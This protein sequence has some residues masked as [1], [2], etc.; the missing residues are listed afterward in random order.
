SMRIVDVH[1]H[2]YPK[3]YVA[4]LERVVANDSTTWGR[5]V[6]FHTKERIGRDPR[7]T[8]INAHLEDMD[9]TGVEV[10]ALSLSIPHVYFEEE[11]DSVEAA[12][13][14]NDA[15]AA[16]CAQYPTRFKGLAMLP[17]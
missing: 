2:F 7:M 11:R 12:R 17:L 8:N 10:Q 14:T 4:L 13:I 6:Y 1:A 16:L 5:A 9:R 3:D 15:L